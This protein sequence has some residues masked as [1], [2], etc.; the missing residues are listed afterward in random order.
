MLLAE[1]LKLNF[2]NLRETQL[3]PRVER[4]K[5]LKHIHAV[6]SAYRSGVGCRVTSLMRE[7]G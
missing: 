4:R 6:E 7:A 1:K 2:M 3:R 5:I